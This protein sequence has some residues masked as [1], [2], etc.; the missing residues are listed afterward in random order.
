MT[1]VDNVNFEQIDYF[2][3]KFMSDYY[4]TFRSMVEQGK[5]DNEFI[6]N[7]VQARGISKTIFKHIVRSYH[8][9]CDVWGVRK[10]MEELDLPN[11]KRMESAIYYQ[12]A[13]W[14]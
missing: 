2:I 1:S 8:V 13:D 10:V 9:E 12:L 14:M 7:H 5:E 3:G 4:D 11:Y 6:P